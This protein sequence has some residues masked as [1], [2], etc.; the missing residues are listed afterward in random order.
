VSYIDDAGGQ[1]RGN[2]GSSRTETG[3]W[4]FEWGRTANLGHATSPA[5]I[6][7]KAGESRF[8]SY[9][10]NNRDPDTTYYWRLCADD[11]DPQHP[12]PGCSSVESFTTDPAPAGV[13]LGID[14]GLGVF[15]N[16]RPRSL[17]AEGPLRFTG[18]A[19]LSLLDS[20]CA[21]DRFRVYDGGVSIGRTASVLDPPG[22][23]PY[24]LYFEGSYADTDHF[25]RGTF[26]FGPGPYS[27]RIKLLPGD[28][29]L[30]DNS[31]YIRLDTPPYTLP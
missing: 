18:P 12:E 6:D 27:I 19:D 7:F 25:S 10:L 20:Y 9:N 1:L 5:A 21:S 29:N 17:N 26:S 14:S 3:S 2:A 24:E 22:C 23:S 31:G 28:G 16:A 13:D 4:W 15:H 8:V 30:L 11:Q